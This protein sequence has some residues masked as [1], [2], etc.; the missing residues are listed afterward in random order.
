MND[1]TIRIDLPA[2]ESDATFRPTAS[3][4][5]ATLRPT[6][7]DATFRP[8]ADDVDATFRD[9][10]A[11]AAAAD[12]ATTMRTLRHDDIDNQNTAGD[13]MQP[14]GETFLLG[15]DV[16]QKV[17][18]LS[19]HSG[20][21]QVFLVR[22]NGEDYVLKVYYP[23]FNVKKKLLQTVRAMRYEMIVRLLDYGK[24]YIDGKQRNYELMEYLRGGTLQEYQLGGKV[25][26]FRRIALQAAA[27][28]AI[29]HK[30]NILHKD[31]KPSNYFF[32]D[33]K[34][35][36]VV[37]GDFGISSLLDNDGAVH[38]TSQARTPIF[39]APEMY[40]DVID[41]VVELTPAADY[42]SLGITLFALWLGTNPL[43]SN[44]RVMMRQKNEGRLPGISELP[45]EIRRLIQGLT[46]VN[47]QSRW[48]YTQVEQW[49]LGENV[50]VDISS[51]FLK[52][53]SF[54]VDPDRNLVAD[55]VHELIPLLLDNE[56]LAINYLYNG[57]VVNWLE[58]CGNNKLSTLVKDI[59]TNRYP[60]DTK[61]GL[62]ASVY[63]MEPSYPY[64]DIAGDTCDDVHDI[65]L[66]ML[67]SQEKYAL[68]LQNPNDNLFLWLESHTKLNV[69]RLRGYFTRE[70]SHQWTKQEAH[71]AVMRMV[72]EIDP[73][74]PFLMRQPS[75]T[76]HDIVRAYGNTAASED[77][78]HALTDG[79]LLSW[80][81]AHEDIMACESLRILTENQDYSEQLAYKVLYN[82][83]HSAPYDLHEAD[84][85]ERIGRHI[86]SRLLKAEHLNAADVER[87]M[88]DIIARDG[89]LHYYAQLH[90]WS[91]EMAEAERCFN[92]NSEEN[93]E[94]LG[95]YNIRTALYRYCRILGTTPRYLL[96]D[97][98]MLDTAADLDTADANI[99]RNEIRQGALADWLTVF[100]HE[101][102]TRDFIEEYSYE[103]ELEQWLLVLGKY[104]PQQRW[105]KRFMTA[106]KEMLE[107]V[108]EVRQEWGEAARKET[109]WRWMC[110]SAVAL[111][112]VLV[113]FPGLQRIGYV[114]EHPYLT[115]GLPIGGMSAVIMAV[116]AYFKGY[117]TTFSML[118][119]AAGWATSLI[120]IYA[121]RH[122]AAAGSGWIT[123]T[124]VG[125]TLAYAA[126]CYLTDYR[127]GSQ[128]D[129]KAIRQI[130]NTAGDDIKTSLIEPLYYTFRTRA[131]RFKGSQF[132]VL[133][134]VT[135]QAHSQAGESVLHYVLWTMMTLLVAGELIVFYL[136][137]HVR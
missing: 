116:R 51:P 106:R 56:R 90:G 104:D 27:A 4:S 41:G 11:N 32:R 55:N 46:A 75:N 16:Y 31:I 12:N 77:E 112:L 2:S 127:R 29:C 94:R 136:M 99:I 22:R 53:K 83:D 85:P 20:E 86:A 105:Y 74:I 124:V 118:W 17:E 28:L 43:S 66:S 123:A 52:Y 120:P 3:E 8:T 58:S 101:D 92:L 128:T 63:A 39:A 82:I 129:N 70:K 95:A 37:L 125:L 47:P 73:E 26:T 1:E 6:A 107:R 132:G 62:M 76:I 25:D 38:R 18:T 78:W 114:V 121:V 7:V 89:R 122:T 44:E 35:T 80:L 84:T 48:S 42:Y 15:N 102:P 23:N 91:Q 137:D 97:G 113:F 111:W 79:R 36:E 33:E 96:P 59:I 13:T 60:T 69:R 81:Y 117:G 57:R 133:D 34:Q 135:D 64:T 14:A 108:E 45:E 126:V 54:I 115:I 50:E 130:L 72:Y 30:N 21:A 88:S 119:G 109:R 100:F 40:T 67:G 71:V 9:A 61:A 131:A 24:T 68:L 103:R 49:F 134:D 110:F 65:A 19:D 93:R 98:T 10:A 5:D 87:E